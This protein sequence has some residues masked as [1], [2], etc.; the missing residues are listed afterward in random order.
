MQINQD[1]DVL[2]LTTRLQALVKKHP[3]I[4]TEIGDAVETLRHLERQRDRA[5]EQARDNFAELKT[6][7]GRVNAEHRLPPAPVAA[8][9]GLCSSA[10][11]CTC[12]SQE[13]AAGGRA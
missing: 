1:P 8:G 3:A 11:D 9:C 4:A 5:R 13:P 10:Q 12:P 7:R 6:L 2:R